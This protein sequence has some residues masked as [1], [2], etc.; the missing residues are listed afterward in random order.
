MAV[1]PFSLAIDLHI[2]VMVAV[3]QLNGRLRR[4]RRGWRPSLRLP[5][6][7][8][9]QW[10]RLLVSLRWFWTEWFWAE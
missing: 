5:V 7:L 4:R 6:R 9:R 10:R 1:I 3:V 2:I 8:R